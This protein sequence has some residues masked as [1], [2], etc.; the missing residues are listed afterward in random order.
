MTLQTA[1]HRTERREAGNPHSVDPVGADP[2]THARAFHISSQT[3]IPRAETWNLPSSMSVPQSD[4]IVVIAG[5][6]HAVGTGAACARLFSA[7]LGCKVALIS[8]PRQE[9][10]EL[11]KE[12]GESGGCVR[13]SYPEPTSMRDGLGG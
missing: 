3:H 11:Q 7:Q 4:Q 1:P 12:L 8:R 10:D 2:P 9:V 6:G 13:N 5:L